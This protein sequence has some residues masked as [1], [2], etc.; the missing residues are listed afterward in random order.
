MNKYEI[1]KK[2]EEFA[3]PELAESWDCSGWLVETE[4]YNI[5]RVMLALTVTEDVIKQAADAG[6]EMII[7][8]HPLFTV[9]IEWKKIDIYCAH[10]NLDKTSGG[11]T[12][13]L[14]KDLG[15]KVNEKQD[16][17]RFVNCEYEVDEFIEKLKKISPNLRYVNNKNIKIIK[18][19]AFCAGSGFEFIEPAKDFGADA[20]VSGE[21]KFHKALESDIVLFDAGHFETETGVLKVLADVLNDVK[22]LYA[23]EHNPFKYC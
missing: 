10:T 14:I 11:T 20:L 3:P 15:L 19:I 22:V 17:L 16:F 4:R 2:T 1:I 7:S 21:L 12:D 13:T 23:K 8:H 5:S 18:K 6:C 9:P